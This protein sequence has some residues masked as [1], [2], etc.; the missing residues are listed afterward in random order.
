MTSAPKVDSLEIET[1]EY[2]VDESF[3]L[4]SI[5]ELV[6]TADAP[7]LVSSAAPQRFTVTMTYFDTPDQRLLRA[8][9]GLR[10]ETGGP[11]AGWHLQA[12]LPDGQVHRARAALGRSERTVPLPLRRLVWVHV[13]D[14]ALQPVASVTSQREVQHFAADGAAPVSL[15]HDRTELVDH[16]D[17][18]GP[19][20]WQQVRVELP[21]GAADVRK[22]V[23][24][25]LRRLG[26]Q[27]AA[28][29][30]DLGEGLN[31]SATVEKGAVAKPRRRPKLS[32]SSTAG[33]VVVAYLAQELGSMLD[34]DL[35]VRLDR[36]NSIHQMRVATRRLRSALRTFGPLFDPTVTGPVAE[37]LTWLAAELGRARD[38]EV[39]RD[40]LLDAVTVEQSRQQ[41][42][43]AVTRTVD[44]ETRRGQRE[45]FIGVRAALGSERYRQLVT[46]LDL[47]VSQPPLT[48][49][50]GKPARKQ[51]PR[52]VGRTADQVHRSLAKAAALPPGAERSDRLH[53]TRKAAK[54][55]RYAAEAVVPA[56]GKPAAAFAAA[57]ERL[58]DTL[59]QHHD[60][61]VMQERLKELALDGS[62][63]AAFALGRLHAQQSVQQEEIESAVARA[64][65]AAEK[66]SLRAWLS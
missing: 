39:L 25:Q 64:A 56:L 66:K 13:R 23:N 40:R 36:P 60:S 47:L 34:E 53:R 57:M 14:A 61:V 6:M 48:A 18:A 46:M 49:R 12:R 8:G 41:S 9:I 54:R 42:N 50:A 52:L 59:G 4:T 1:L 19:V 65:A 35:A 62:S 45:A 15:T 33:E 58:Q 31:R 38:A 30:S 5:P 22:R 17:G 27:R 10:R 55:A 3:E 44:R 24:R 11:D 7:N 20:V 32:P 51:L 26:A 43:G 2:D 28:T 16:L 21:E 37:E 29:P 63:E